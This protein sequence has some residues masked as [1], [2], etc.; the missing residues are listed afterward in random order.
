MVSNNARANQIGERSC[1]I[2]NAGVTTA[3]ANRAYIHAT[4]EA[5]L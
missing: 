3:A 2:D 1:V 4:A 5:G